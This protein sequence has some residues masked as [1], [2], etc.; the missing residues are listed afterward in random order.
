MEN[1][2]KNLLKKYWL[3]YLF[4]WIGYCL[5][6]LTHGISYTVELERCFDPTNNEDYVIEL[7]PCNIAIIILLFVSSVLMAVSKKNLIKYKWLLVIVS[8]GLAVI[9]PILKE[10]TTGF[11]AD[12]FEAV[13]GRKYIYYGLINY[14]WIGNIP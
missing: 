6:F 12:F 4:I 7:L 5:L 10:T 8:L 2:D 14:Y 9:M 1:N 13:L 11:D 3:G